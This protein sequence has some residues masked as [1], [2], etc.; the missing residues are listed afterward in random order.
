MLYTNPQPWAP[1]TPWWPFT[2]TTAGSTLNTEAILKPGDSM[3]KVC[4][5][6]GVYLEVKRIDGVMTRTLCRGPN[7]I[8]LSDAAFERL[9]AEL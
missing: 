8:Q 4:L 9:C 7:R 5:D 6:E 2:T 1:S 3:F